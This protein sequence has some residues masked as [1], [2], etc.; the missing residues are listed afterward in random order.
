MV[1]VSRSLGAVLPAAL[2]DRLSQRELGRHLGIGLPFITIDQA[3]RPHAMVVSYLEVRAHS[4]STLG[5]VIQ[6][7]S[8]SARNLAARGAGTLLIV[9]PDAVFYVKTRAVDGPL[10]VGD[11]EFGLGYFLLAVEEVLE[12]TAG[13]WE[14]GVLITNAI[15]YRPIPALDAPWERATLAA[16]ATPRARV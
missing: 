5:L 8:T 15:E 2:V 6:A 10:E 16:L 14:S 13:A 7:G 4:P 3:G 11:D 1:C 9:E 12:D